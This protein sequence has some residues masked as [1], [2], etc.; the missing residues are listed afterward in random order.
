M[1]VGNISTLA[2]IAAS[3]LSLGAY[4]SAL[5]GRGNGGGMGHGNSGIA[6]GNSSF[7]RSQGSAHI[8]KH[9]TRGKSQLVH[10]NNVF[11]HKQGNPLTRTRGSQNNAFGK[12]RSAKDPT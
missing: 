7:G 5:G 4:S 11:G 10:G 2:V 8:K 6:P 3:C 12:S 9:T 1:K